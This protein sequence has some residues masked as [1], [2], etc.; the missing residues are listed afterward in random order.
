MVFSYIKKISELVSSMINRTKFITGY[1]T[2]NSLQ[3]P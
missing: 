1:R 2:F 3:S